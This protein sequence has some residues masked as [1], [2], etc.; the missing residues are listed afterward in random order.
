M[1]QSG[2]DA[3]NNALSKHS[4]SDAVNTRSFQEVLGLAK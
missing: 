1:Y 4:S 3:T 2:N